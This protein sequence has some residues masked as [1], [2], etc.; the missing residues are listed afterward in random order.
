MTENEKKITA[1][2]NQQTTE[3]EQNENQN[4]E[5]TFSISEICSKYIIEK[6]IS[7]TVTIIHSRNLETN[8]GEFCFDF[9]KNN[10]N[11]YLNGIFFSHEEG[12]ETENNNFFFKIPIQKEKNTWIEINE[13][14]S[15]IEDTYLQDRIKFEP[16]LNK[17]ETNVIKDTLSE[18]NITNT[19]KPEKK[20]KIK[21]KMK[22]LYFQKMANI[23]VL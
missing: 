6:L 18:F 21:K 23:K 22:F 11:P 17:D 1:Q 14:E 2:E 15:A 8:F 19:K 16:F 10:I 5:P 12:T 9:I 3:N 20:P 4:E 13:P 7:Q